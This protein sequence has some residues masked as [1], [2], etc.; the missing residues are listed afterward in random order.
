MKSPLSPQTLKDIRTAFELIAIRE[1]ELLKDAGGASKE[2]PRY[3]DEPKTTHS[4]R[5][6]PPRRHLDS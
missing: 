4:V 5:I 6:T 1:Q 3:P 2:R